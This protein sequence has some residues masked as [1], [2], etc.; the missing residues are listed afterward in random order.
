M[1]ISS[2]EP[3]KKKWKKKNNKQQNR[4]K[5]EAVLFLEILTPLFPLPQKLEQMIT[6]YSI[7]KMKVFK[8]S[9]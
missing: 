8:M 1:R 7:K 4:K 2:K 5:Q 6:T 9:T 3:W